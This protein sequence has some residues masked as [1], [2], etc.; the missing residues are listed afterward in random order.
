MTP[1]PLHTLTTFQLPAYANA[2]SIIHTQNDLI[3]LFAHT[4]P[5]VYRVLGHGSNTVF[6]RNYDGHILVMK[7]DDYH[8]TPISD[9]E[10]HI[11][12][13][14]G[15]SWHDLVLRT[16]EQGYGGL[17]NLSLIP[18]TVGSS[19]IQNIGAYGVEA[20]D[21][22]VCV[23]CFD[24]RTQTF[25]EYSHSMCEFGYRTSIFKRSPHLIVTHVTYTLT[26][27]KHTMNTRYGDITA[28]LGDTIP[29]PRTVSDAI[30]AIRSSKLP[31]PHVVYNAGSFFK[32]PVVHHSV[33]QEVLKQFPTMPVYPHNQTHQKVSAGWLIEQCGLKGY[34]YKH[35]GV[36]EKHALVLVHYGGGTYQE[37]EEL[38]KH[39]TTTVHDT[40]GITLEPEVDIV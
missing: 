28:V 4:N 1:Y 2:C 12:V 16:I 37:L 23:T 3:E 17:E 29:T 9:N 6:S 15:Y 34:R 8:E 5:L 18:G 21:R 14:A 27:H 22:I 40:F 10:I 13:G 35:C 11:C 39:I 30:I 19:P 26:R 24:T 25:V 31:D 7:I 33:V 20:S 38:V 32:N 36:Y